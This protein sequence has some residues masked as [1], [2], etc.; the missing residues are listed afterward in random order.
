MARPNRSQAGL[1]RR[2]QASREWDRRNPEK[3]AIAGRRYRLK[4]KYG[5]SLEDYELMLASQGG[6]CAI[7]A[8]APGKGVLHVDHCHTT[9]RVRGLLCHKCN[10]A[11]G[12]FADSPERLHSAATYLRVA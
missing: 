11:L 3:R 2:H 10:K 8:E 12:L 1:E 7:C 5:V 9:G 4:K 6:V